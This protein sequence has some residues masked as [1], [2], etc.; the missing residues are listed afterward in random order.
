MTLFT[1]SQLPMR[2]NST[3]EKEK[4]DDKKKKGHEIICYRALNQGIPLHQIS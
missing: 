3:P 2:K 4:R 1:A